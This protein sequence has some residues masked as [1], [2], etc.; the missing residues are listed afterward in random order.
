MTAETIR[1][2]EAE[3]RAAYPATTAATEGSLRLIRLP[4]VHFS[5]GCR[6]ATGSALVVLD[7]NAPKPDM[8][9]SE[10]PALPSG[11]RVSVGTVTVAGQSW[12]TFSFNVTWE[13]GR[14]TAIQFLEGKL[15]RLR[16]G[17]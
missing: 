15:A 9:L 7:P 3:L 13:E 4:E 10:V 8:Y 12:Q 6:P 17:S 2:I 1:L 5:S 11:N 14:H 16:R